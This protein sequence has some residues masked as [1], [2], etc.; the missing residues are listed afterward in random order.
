MT[1]PEPLIDRC[2]CEEGRLLAVLQRFRAE[3][4][5]DLVEPDGAI[6]ANCQFCARLYR[7]APEKLK[8]G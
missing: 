2:S 6:H 3:E 7:V 1:E 8:A 5:A 4:I